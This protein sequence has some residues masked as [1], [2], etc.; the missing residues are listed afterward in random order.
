MDQALACSD[1][2]ESYEL[3]QKAQ[4]D[5]TTGVTQDGDIPWVWLVNVDH[6]YWVREG[7]V[8]YTHLDVYKRQVI[9]KGIPLLFSAITTIMISK[10]VLFCN[11]FQKKKR[12]LPDGGQTDI[13]KPSAEAEK[14]IRRS[15]DT[16]F[17]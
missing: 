8:S 1:L 2:E 17:L 11:C 7:P 5:G 10:P 9:Y 3:W 4:W 16:Y 13:I 6:L 12:D 14:G 15:P